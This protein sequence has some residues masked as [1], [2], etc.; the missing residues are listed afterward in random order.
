MK[1]NK[2]LELSTVM[3]W[4]MPAVT[5]MIWSMDTI[6]DA[7]Q[8]YGVG[9]GAGPDDDP[10]KQMRWFLLSQ[11]NATRLRIPDEVLGIIGGYSDYNEIKTLFRILK[12]SRD[13]KR[14][15]GFDSYE[16]M[17]EVYPSRVGRISKVRYLTAVHRGF[18]ME[19]DGWNNFA[20]IFDES[21]TFIED[22]CLDGFWNGTDFERDMNPVAIN[23]DAFRGFKYLKY[24]SMQ[25]LNLT[26]SMDDLSKLPNTVVSLKLNGNVWSEQSGDL[27]L[28]LL[29]RKL[30]HFSVDHCY[31]MNGFLSFTAPHSELRELSMIGVDIQDFVNLYAPPP[32]LRQITLDLMGMG[33][34]IPSTTLK[35]MQSNWSIVFVC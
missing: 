9:A 25:H 19:V 17:H 8:N 35:F 32:Y 10:L 11:R 1:M 26:L 4:T 7:I 2:I 30:Q 15:I 12:T 6:C 16:E 34:S 14:V 22:I 13:R 23:W 27:D 5:I 3:L 24:L 31:G 29:P 28:N 18:S 20:F 21:K 33:S